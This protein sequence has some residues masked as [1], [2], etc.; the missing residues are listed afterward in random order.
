MLALFN[1]FKDPWFEDCTPG[2]HRSVGSRLLNRIVEVHIGVDVTISASEEFSRRV[3][4]E[5][6]LLR[7]TVFEILMR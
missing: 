7:G 5:C 6:D 1:L 2:D 3:P 4:N